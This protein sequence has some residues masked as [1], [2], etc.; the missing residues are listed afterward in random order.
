MYFENY[1]QIFIIQ[2][3]SIQMST[4]I[5]LFIIKDES[6]HWGTIGWSFQ[7]SCHRNDIQVDLPTLA[8]ELLN[9][10]PAPFFLFSCFYVSALYVD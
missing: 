1:D 5:Q 2:D 9:S 10:Y 4:L 8:V 7:F 6:G 3:E